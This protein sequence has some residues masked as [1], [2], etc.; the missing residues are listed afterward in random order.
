MFLRFLLLI[1]SRS[2]ASDLCSLQDFK[3][4]IPIFVCRYL[5]ANCFTATTWEKLCREDPLSSAGGTA[6]SSK[7]LQHGAEEL[8][9]LLNDFLKKCDRGILLRLIFRP[10]YF[11]FDTMMNK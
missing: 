6:L 3:K 4:K 8:S 10:F 5:Y 11:L 2:F 7:F 1:D 9:D